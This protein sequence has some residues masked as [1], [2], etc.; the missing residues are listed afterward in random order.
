MKKHTLSLLAGVALALTATT[1]VAHYGHSFWD[2]VRYDVRPFLGVD[3]QERDM[4]FQ[5]RFGD[6]IWA[7]D[8]TQFDVYGGIRIFH[9]LGLSV[10]YEKSNTKDRDFTINDGDTYL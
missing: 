2:D 10:G 6:N 9:Y 7:D 4:D 8:F 3:I 1:S 5:E